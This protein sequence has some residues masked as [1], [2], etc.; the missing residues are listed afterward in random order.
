M[1]ELSLNILDVAKNSTAAGASLVEISLELSSEGILTLSIVDNGCGMSEETLLGVTNPFYT[2]RKTRK[3][4]MGLP[5]LKMAAEMTGGGLTITS[6][7]KVGESGTSLVATFDT[8]SIDCMPLGD[9]VSTVCI[10]I[11]GSPEVDFVFTDTRPKGRVALATAELRAVLGE[12]ISLAEMEVQQWI[13]EY[14][15]EQ[16]R[17]IEAL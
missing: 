14:L 2:T 5:L 8:K 6:S 9:I 1:K 12:G 17:E 13:K 4:G 16:Y 15:E 10:L 3:V 11:A 7:D